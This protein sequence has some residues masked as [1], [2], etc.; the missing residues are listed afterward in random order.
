MPRPRLPK[1]WREVPGTVLSSLLC[2][3]ALQVC[4]IAWGFVLDPPARKSDVEALRAQVQ[5]LADYIAKGR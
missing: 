4:W 5:H 2:A 3:L 1:I